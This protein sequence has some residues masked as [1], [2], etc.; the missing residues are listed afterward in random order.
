MVCAMVLG[1]LDSRAERILQRNDNISGET[2]R[3]T[4]IK[5]FKSTFWLI[6]VIC[7][8]YYVAIFPFITV[9]KE[10]FMDR[11]HMSKQD[12][13][14]VS[15]LVYLISGIASPVF[16]LFIDKIGKNV[17]WISIAVLATILSHVLLGFTELNPY[18]GVVNSL[19]F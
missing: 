12:A 15:S 3:L 6:T 5:D 14:N 10:F 18:V 19:D 16:G 8:T 2:V 13:N 7:V 9:A 17:S 11:F 1:V 4:D